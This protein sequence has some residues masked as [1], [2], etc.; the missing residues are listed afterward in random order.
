[1]G[2]LVIDVTMTLD[3]YHACHVGGRGRV[4]DVTWARTDAECPGRAPNR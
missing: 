1:M 2:Q 4:T 3:G